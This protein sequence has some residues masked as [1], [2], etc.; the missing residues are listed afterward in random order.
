MSFLYI[1]KC[2]LKWRTDENKSL[3]SNQF[4]LKALQFKGRLYSK[5]SYKCVNYNKISKFVKNV[6]S[7][8]KWL[9]VFV[10]CTSKRSWSL[11]LEEENIRA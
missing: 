1:L 8:S 9:S 11:N 4:S 5:L 10:T 3:I 7:S 2:D 6:S